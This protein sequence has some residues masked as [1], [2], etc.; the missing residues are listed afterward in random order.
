I[1][2]EPPSVAPLAT[3]IA[4]VADGPKLPFKISVPALTEIAP[5]RRLIGLV[6]V[7][8]P[9]PFLPNPAEVDVVMLLATTPVIGPLNGMLWPLVSLTIV[10]GEPPP[11]K[12]TWRLLVTSPSSVSVVG[13]VAVPNEKLQAPPTPV[14]PSPAM[15]V[16]PAV[17]RVAP[18][19][20]FPV[21]VT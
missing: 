10:A 2:P 16:F 7:S 5:C 11:S 18:V 4:L 14:H 9:A 20:V 17:N 3:V 1:M 19:Y 13:A 15:W 21:L 8:V 12:L 6:S